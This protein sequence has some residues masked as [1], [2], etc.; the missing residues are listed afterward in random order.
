MNKRIIITIVTLLTV[1]SAS[2]GTWLFMEKKNDTT[3]IL[4]THQKEVD[5]NKEETENVQDVEVQEDILS[6][7]IESKDIGKQKNPEKAESAE[8][9][10]STEVVKETQTK[11]TSKEQLSTSKIKDNLISWGH[12]K[13]S[14]RTIDTIIVHSVYNATGG[15]EHDLKKIL[16]IFKDYDVSAHYIIERDGTIN[17]LV[18]EKDVSWHAGAGQTPDGRSNVNGFS[19]GIEMI[20]QK[21]VGYKSAQYD[22]LKSLI[23]DIEGRYNIKYVIGHKDIAPDRKEDPWDFDWDQ[24]GGKRQ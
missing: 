13:T 8:P 19:I 10:E 11:D 14:G 4:N 20:A 9:A 15:D 6:E 2:V 17:R 12:Q 16:G 22:A 23:K 18:N 21:G 5:G 7:V 24:I 3:I 1:I